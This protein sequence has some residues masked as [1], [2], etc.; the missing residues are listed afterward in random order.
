MKKFLLILLAL[1]IGFSIWTEQAVARFSGEG[2][3]G[4]IR[5]FFSHVNIDLDMGTHSIDGDSSTGLAFDPDN[6]GTDEITFGTDGSITME[7]LAVGYGTL[8][9]TQEPNASAPTVAVNVSAGNL[10]GAYRYLVTFVTAE[11]ETSQ[12]TVSSSVSPVNQQ[13]DLSSIPT[14]TSRVTARKIYRTVAGDAW[15]YFCQL[16][17]TINDNTTTTYTDNLVDASLGVYTPG[18]NTTG[19]G[20]TLNDIK[21][22]EADEGVTIL[23]YNAGKVNTGYS[24]SFIGASAGYSNTTGYY[25]SLI[26]ASAGYSNTTGYYNSL[27]GV[28]AGYSNTTGYYNSLIGASA[29][30]SNTTGYYNSFIGMN[31][32]Y[33]NTTGYSNS[34]IGA[35]AGYSNTTGYY[36]SLIGMNAGD[37]LTSGNSNIVIGTDVDSPTAT[38]SNTLTIGNLIF[39]TSLDGTGTTISTGN[40]GIGVINPGERLEV[41]GNIFL[42]DNDKSIYGTGKDSKDYYDG[43]N[44]IIDPNVVGTGKVLIG[45]TADDDLGLENLELHGYLKTEADLITDVAPVDDTTQKRLSIQKLAA[46]P[47]NAAYIAFSNNPGT[48]TFYL[49]MEEGD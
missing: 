21:G 28:S 19:G 37:N 4:G 29:G 41:N 34:F 47:T 42:N 32:G 15:P 33:S 30:Y 44:R 12:G 36:N 18:N 49:V 7:K 14:G 23:G 2:A 16:V 46:P 6:D 9:F 43:T 3:F 24:N 39:G 40:I 31:A 17:T 27:I 22:I 48:D 11:G 38:N 1:S 8:N 20:I 45:A 35:S 25:N 10:N 13:V 26:G 5:N